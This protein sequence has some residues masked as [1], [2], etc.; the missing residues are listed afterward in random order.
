MSL[1]VESECFVWSFRVYSQFTHIIICISALQVPFWDRL[2]SN[3]VGTCRF[4]I[5]PCS[6]AEQFST[7]NPP[8]CRILILNIIVLLHGHVTKKLQWS[9]KEKITTIENSLKFLF[10]LFKFKKTRTL[11][12]VWLFL[13]IFNALHSTGRIFDWFHSN[14]EVACIKNII[15]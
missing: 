5:V 8:L 10:L 6:L 11:L 14:F 2:S 3:L 1:K 7:L 12:N 9:C 4:V 13:W 15:D